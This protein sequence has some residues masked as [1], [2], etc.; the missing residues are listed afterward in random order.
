MSLARDLWAF[1]TPE[2]LSQEEGAIH[3]GWRMA[4][5]ASGSL[6][7]KHAPTGRKTTCVLDLDVTLSLSLSGNA[8]YIDDGSCPVPWPIP[9]SHGPPP[10]SSH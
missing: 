6:W 2:I 7:S 4:G 8:W 10:W 9:E 1:S 5:L 3:S